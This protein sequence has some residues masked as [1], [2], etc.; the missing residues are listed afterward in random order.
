MRSAGWWLSFCLLATCGGR[1]EKDDQDGDGSRGATG[2]NGGTGGSATTGGTGAVG[3]PSEWAV[4]C[5][6]SAR[7]TCQRWM[8]CS[9]HLAEVVLPANCET[10][11]SVECLIVA[12]LPGVAITPSEYSACVEEFERLSCEDWLYGGAFTGCQTPGTLP[13]G[14]LC[15]SGLQCASGECSAELGCG[16]C[17]TNALVGENCK[18]RACA[19]GLECTLDGV[20][21]EA[22]Y[23]GDA[24][25]IDSPCVKALN[26]V[27]GVC[28]KK[29][30]EGTSCAGDSLACDIVQGLRCGE[31]NLCEPIATPGIGEAC[32]GICAAGAACTGTGRCAAAASEGQA[33]VFDELGNALC[34]RTLEC[35]NGV[36]TRF[37]PALCE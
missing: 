10:S 5:S 37:D 32:F 18:D 21:T 35:I 34:D 11:L 24:C 7:V 28:A 23:L 27:D 16:T 13:D 15:S 12:R 17:G 20:C 22:R 8:A 1:S 31:T 4:A 14:S 36:C 19:N 6:Q 9:P 25:D 29:G 3:G 30:V 26:C 33:C 2:G